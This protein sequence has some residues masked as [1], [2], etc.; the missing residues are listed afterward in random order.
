MS[1]PKSACR[2]WNNENG[3]D[4]L[5]LYDNQTGFV[6]GIDNTGTGWGS[7]ASALPS[8][9]VQS[10]LLA[11]YRIQSSESVA[12]LVDYS[13]NGNNATGT[14]G[15]APTVLAT[16]GG[17]NCTGNGAVSLPASLNSALSIM[18]LCAS[19]YSAVNPSAFN[20]PLHSNGGGSLGN[21]VGLCVGTVNGIESIVNN[22]NGIQ[23]GGVFNGVGV[24]SLVMNNRDTI[25]INDIAGTAYTATTNTAAGVVTVG[26]YQLGGTA[27]GQG[28]EYGNTYFTGQIYYALFYNRLLSAAEV[29]QNVD[30]MK[31]ALLNRGLPSVSFG[32][33]ATDITGILVLNGDSITQ[34]INGYPIITAA[35]LTNI[36]LGTSSITAALV[37]Q[38]ASY[39]TT[40]LYRPYAGQNAV[41]VWLGTNDIFF[42]A[43]V[44]QT[45]QNFVA[46]CQ[47]ARKDGYRVIAVTMLDRYVDPTSYSTQSQ[48]L[49][50]LIRAQWATFADGLA[51]VAANPLLGATSAAQNATYFPDGTHPSALSNY[52]IIVPVLQRAVNRIYGNNDFSSANTYTTTASAAASISAA[53]TNGSTLVA[54]ITSTLYPPVGSM[55]TI[56]GVTPSGY[57][58]TWLVLSS[59]S[60]QFTF[61]V[62]SALGVGSGFGTAAIPTMLDTDVYINLGGSATTPNFT[63]QSSVGLTGQKIYIKNTSATSTWTITP[64]ASETIDGSSSITLAPGAKT[65]LES[66]LVSASAVGSNWIT[67]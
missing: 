2:T 32:S 31:N 35:P 46:C 43:T 14:V 56:A 28:F 38:Q 57:N 41:T 26:N 10:G 3:K 1:N 66:V 30:V 42:G 17:L 39:R 9:I 15:T 50:T 51:D 48:A 13:G 59:S 18:I 34:H 22:N 60:S 67:V 8:G 12:A 63:L 54:T 62:G 52:N 49:N 61:Y 58:G 29:A 5:A 20:C 19:T 55:V 21:D 36:G 44:A 45:F 65:V 24:I 37:A 33:I 16:T 11:E 47:S 4:F 64:F 23:I 6:G 53:S 40:A 7:L 25:Y 27:S